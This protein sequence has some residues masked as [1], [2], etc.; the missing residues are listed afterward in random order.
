MNLLRLVIP[1]LQILLFSFHIATKLGIRLMDVYMRK[2][3]AKKHFS[4]QLANDGIPVETIRA[5][6]QSYMEMLP[7]DLPFITQLVKKMNHK[8]K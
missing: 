4:Q 2:Q 3:S 7:F 1:C 8:K 5:L 6:T